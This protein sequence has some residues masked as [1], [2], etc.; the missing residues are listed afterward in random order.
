MEREGAQPTGDT[1]V[2]RAGAR[3]APRAVALMI[4]G[5]SALVAAVLARATPAGDGPGGAPVDLAGIVAAVEQ[6]LLIVG[7]L[8][9][10]AVAVGF[11]WVVARG[12]AVPR[13]RST[14]QQ[15]RAI[16]TFVLMVYLVVVLLGVVLPRLFST[17]GPGGPDDGALGDAAVGASGGGPT[18]PVAVVLVA[19]VVS[20]VAWWRLRDRFEADPEAVDAAARDVLTAAVE[21][22]DD[23]AAV[24]DV[25]IAAYARLQRA[26][27]D[28]GY[29][30]AAAETTGAYVDRVLRHRM[31][32]SDALVTLTGV[33]ERVRFGTAAA[34]A[35]ERRGAVTAL[36]R[37]L[38]GLRHG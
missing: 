13:D 4:L 32:D 15:L 18:W 2:G 21:E 30:R 33:Y 24:D 37:A 35:A 12:E 22:T 19:A 7:V 5:L 6:G 11:V 10:A 8:V 9:A 14:T 28:A 38:D 34:T 31:G 25:V 20:L 1:A 27:A 29:P 23:G 17:G 36:R 26:F 16:A 3:H